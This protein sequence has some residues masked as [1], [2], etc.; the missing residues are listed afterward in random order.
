M[1][2]NNTRTGKA[3]IPEKGIRAAYGKLQIPKF[4]EGFNILYYVTISGDNTF[5]TTKWET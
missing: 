4:S 5:T 1:E 3:C 2:R